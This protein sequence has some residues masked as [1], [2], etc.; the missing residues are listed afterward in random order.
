MGGR[1]VRVGA[2]TICVHSD[3]P[4]ALEIAAAAE[5]AF[6][7]RPR[8]VRVLSEASDEEDHVFCF[9][10]ARTASAVIGMCRTRMP[11]AL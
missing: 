9:K 8:T 3:A 5:E 11:T 2:D 1:E 6:R 4:N 10:P 7:P